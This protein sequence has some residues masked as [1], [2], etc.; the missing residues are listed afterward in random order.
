MDTSIFGGEDSSFVSF[1]LDQEEY[2][3][4][5]GPDTTI[6]SIEV[7]RNALSS[8]LFCMSELCFLVILDCYRHWN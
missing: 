8:F 5:F 3:L 6:Q 2:T 7:K 1:M 4:E